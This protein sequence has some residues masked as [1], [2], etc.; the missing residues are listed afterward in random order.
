MAIKAFL[1]RV[2]E[3]L[4]AYSEADKKEFR[5]TPRDVPVRAII[6][7]PRSLGMH[8][9]GFAFM[10]AVFD[11]QDDFDDFDV[12]RKWLTMKAGFFEVMV[13][14]GMSMGGRDVSAGEI[15]LPQSLAFENMEEAEFRSCIQK[16]ITAFLNSVCGHGLSVKNIDQAWSEAMSWT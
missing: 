14:P 12:F 15:F 6:T 7:T 16:M 13:V 3:T 2:G 10:Q 5:K 8:K 9:R 11:L 1:R 4:I